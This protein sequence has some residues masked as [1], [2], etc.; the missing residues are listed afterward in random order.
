MRARLSFA[1]A[2]VFGRRRRRR[3][4]YFGIKQ[5]CVN[6]KS[7]P[8]RD[9]AQLGVVVGEGEGQGAGVCYCCYKFMQMQMLFA[10][11]ISQV[12]LN[13][14]SANRRNDHVESV[15]S[16]HKSPAPVTHPP[17]PAAISLAPDRHNAR[18]PFTRLAKVSQ[19]QHPEEINY[20]LQLPT[21]DW[22]LANCTLLMKS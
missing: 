11:R 16:T 15:S 1:V 19:R 18:Q 6:A 14:L 5:R 4:V 8:R 12:Y 22:Q 13:S 20:N 3:C 2:Q 17:S 9:K 7:L 10:F 21:G